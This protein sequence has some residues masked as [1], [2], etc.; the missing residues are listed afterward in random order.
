MKMSSNSFALGVFLLL[1]LPNTS[2]ALQTQNPPSIPRFEIKT[3]EKNSDAANHLRIASNDSLLADSLFS[4]GLT[5]VYEQNFRLAEVHFLQALHALPE[6]GSK[7]KKAGILYEMAIVNERLQK[8]AD[9]ET[10]LREA[11]RLAIEP[12]LR[13]KIAQ[14]LSQANYYRRRFET[15]QSPL[16]SEKESLR[17]E[18]TPLPTKSIANQDTF[19]SRHINNDLFTTL[20]VD[21]ADIQLSKVGS[22]QHTEQ[23]KKIS[24]ANLIE[25]SNDNIIPWDALASDSIHGEIELTHDVYPLLYS[26]IK[27]DNKQQNE[28]IEPILQIGLQAISSTIIGFAS[29]LFIFPTLRARL[30]FVLGNY[31]R[32]IAICEKTLARTPHR[33]NLYTMLV[34]AYFSTDTKHEKAFKTYQMVRMLNI[35]PALKKNS[36]KLLAM[37]NLNEDQPDEFAIE[38]MESALKK[39]LEKKSIHSKIAA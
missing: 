6:S 4:V 26:E 37:H 2:K 39:E 14:Q 19:S 24:D 27:I 10:N 5:H 38:V 16:F 22:L 32:T 7:N 29:I 34:Y 30:C 3:S 13:A 12:S 21:S 15:I 8:Y 36:T 17:T 28:T 23:T 9:Y 18:T 31:N 33:I 20:S 25:E 1:F 35:N 11:K